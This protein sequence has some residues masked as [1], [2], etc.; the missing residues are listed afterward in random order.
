MTFEQFQTTRTEA[1]DLANAVPDTFIDEDGALPQPGFVYLDV[2]YIERVTKDWPSAAQR[3]AYH[4]LI[5][6]QEWITDDLQS[7][8]ERLYDY[9]QSEGYFDA[10]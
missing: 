2:F 10:R 6:N 5:C 9:A 4:L 3:G 7:L 8:E 1:S